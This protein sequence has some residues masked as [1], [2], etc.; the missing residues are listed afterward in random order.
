M[1]HIAAVN[2]FDHTVSEVLYS[3]TDDAIKLRIVT[4]LLE[5]LILHK[6]EHV[7]DSM[8]YDNPTVVSALQ[9]IRRTPRG[10]AHA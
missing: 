1:N 5:Q 3:N 7:E 9:Q 10:V 6:W 2:I 8:F 4:T